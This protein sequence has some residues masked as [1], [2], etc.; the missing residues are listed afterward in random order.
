M[1]QKSWHF[2]RRTFLRG[3]G[4]LALSLPFLNAMGAEKA[5]S[6]ATR[7]KR[8]AFISFPNG[9]SLPSVKN[10][11]TKQWHWFPEKLTKGYRFRESQKY[12]TPFKDDITVIS[13]LSHP[14]YR[15]TSAVHAV[16]AGFLTGKNFDKMGSLTNAVSID[17]V[18]ANGL[19][20]STYMDS[21]ALSSTGGVGALKRNFT[22][23]YTANGSPIPAENDLQRIYEKLFMADSPKAKASLKS[24]ESLV[25]AVL[26]DSKKVAKLLGQEDKK[27]YDEYLSSIRD[28]E[29]KIQ[30]DQ[31]WIGKLK[32]K[33]IDKTKLSLDVTPKD[34]EKYI[35][36]IY[37]LIFLAFQTDLTR[38]ITY[39]IAAEDEAGA[40]DVL[41]MAS[42]VGAKKTLHRISHTKS[43]AGHKQ[44]GLWDQFLSK[45][46]AYLIN[47]LS[48][49]RE[50]ESRLLDRCMIF[51]GSHTSK[52]H[53]CRN[54]P[55]IL[56]G[57]KDMGLKQGEF[58]RYHEN[59]NALSNLFVKMSHAMDV[60]IK[61]FADSTGVPMNEIF[62]ST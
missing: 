7:P 6:Q 28:V 4:G 35:S 24:K 52:T 32:N 53:V 21:L 44:W 41:N 60:P 38:V 61:S 31:S 36:T 57:G 43:D 1:A 15:K 29:K 14:S 62:A 37:D 45:Q 58:V 22:L 18:I 8:V 51:Q 11:K 47:R 39:Q 48:K 50:G 46:L 23:S 42:V 13:G 9:V 55:L 56:A 5:T 27:T 54:Y 12:L 2:D 25:D 26:D 10:Q 19:S 40:R 16:A 17:Q 3:S 20:G 34:P 33:P 49:T 59:K 30:S